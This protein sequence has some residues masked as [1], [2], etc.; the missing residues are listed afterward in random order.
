MKENES[1]FDISVKKL[2]NDS[3]TRPNLY[4]ALKKDQAAL[5]PFSILLIY[6]KKTLN[7]PINSS[8]SKNPYIY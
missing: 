2:I 3:I 8:T 6:T 5:P 1:F 4:T 7:F